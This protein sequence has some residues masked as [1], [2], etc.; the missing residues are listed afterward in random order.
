[1]IGR[2]I[3]RF[4]STTSSEPSTRFTKCAKE[5]RA[6]AN[7]RKSSC[8]LRGI[9]KISTRS[10]NIGRYLG[11]RE[12]LPQLL[13]FQGVLFVHSVGHSLSYSLIQ[14]NNPIN[15]AYRF[16]HSFKHRTLVLLFILTS[17][18]TFLRSVTRT[19]LTPGNA[20]PLPG[21]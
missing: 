9:P 6:K 5:T 13:K 18:I 1:M 3:G 15:Y 2:D 12:R 16:V 17:G 7:V 21:R 20:L 10:W 8:A 19:M 11:R 4:F 14:E